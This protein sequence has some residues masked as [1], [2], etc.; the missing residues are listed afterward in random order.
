[1]KKTEILSLN[2]FFYVVSIFVLLFA[3][4][5]VFDI[6]SSED[7]SSIAASGNWSSYTDTS[8]LGS[9]T[10]EDPFLITSA[11]DLAGLAY[12]VNISG[13]KYSGKYFE[14]TCNISL[15]AHYWIPIGGGQYGMDKW[16]AGNYN[17]CG[18]NISGLYIS[19]SS[20]VCVG[21]FGIVKGG[22]IK[23]VN[24][25]SGTINGDGDTAAIVG[26]TEG[27]AT[28][29]EYCSNAASV[30]GTWR[31]GGIVGGYQNKWNAG[32][33]IYNCYNKGYVRGNVMVGGILGGQNNNG[34]YGIIMYCY[35]TGTI[36]GDGAGNDNKSL[37]G[38]IVGR[39]AGA[40]GKSSQSG[41]AMN[42]WSTSPVSK[43]TYVGGIA[44][45]FYYCNTDIL[46]NGKNYFNNISDRWGDG[47]NP[48]KNW[49]TYLSNLST[50]AK[51][52]NWYK[53]ASNWWGA[54]DMTSVWQIVGN[55]YPTFRTKTLTLN[56]NGGS[57][58]ADYFNGSGS[59][60]TRY[61]TY[62][63]YYGKLPTPTRTGYTFAGWYTAA[64]GGS[65][66][67]STNVY[68]SGN[69]T[70]FAHWT[71]NTYTV[72]Y[73]LG[74]GTQG[75]YLPTSWTYDVAQQISNPTRTGY[76]FDGWTASG[77][78]T[79]TAV[80]GTS[81]NPTTKWSSASTK[82]KASS[83]TGA[84]YFKNLR[85]TSGTITLT[86]NWTINQYDLNF[87]ANG[88][89]VS[90]QERP[91]NY[92]D[93]YGTLPTPTRT[94]YTFNGWFTAASGGNQVSATTTMGAS[95]TTIYAHWTANTYTVKFNDQSGTTNFADMVLIDSTYNTNGTYTFTRNGVTVTYDVSDSA[96]TLNGTPTNDIN[97]FINLGLSF[98]QNDVYRVSY[99]QISGSMTGSSTGAF[100]LEVCDSTWALLETRNR[101]DFQMNNSS[102]SANLTISS[103]G[104]TQG[105]GLK[106][107]FWCNENAT[108]SRVFNNFKVK[109][110]IEKSGT[111][112]VQKQTR[113]TYGSALEAVAPPTRVG[114][115]FQ[116]YYTQTGGRGTRYFDSSGHPVVSTMNIAN[117]TTTLHA[118]W[119]VKTNCVLTFN[120]NG[121]SVS[122]TSRDQTFNAALGTLPVP[123]RT[124]YIFTGWYT[125]ASGGDEVTSSTIME[126]ES[127]TIYA[128][129]AE[130][131]A[132]SHYSSALTQDSDGY[133]MISSSA[134]LARVLYLLNY[135]TRTDVLTMRFKLTDH[136][137]MSAYYWV[138]AG[139]ESRPFQGEFNG[140]GYTIK[141]LKTVSQSERKDSGG[142]NG[143]LF[144]VTS[145]GAIIKN[146]YLEDIDIHGLDRVGA[147]VGHVKG[148]TTITAVAVEGTVT[149]SGSNYG[150]IV[151]YAD[152][153]GLTN[154]SDC[155]VHLTNYISIRRGNVS[156]TTSI[157]YYSDTQYYYTGSNP[158]TNPSA[159]PNWIQN[160]TGM[161]YT[162][163]PKG[164]AWLAETIGIE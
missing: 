46:Q 20:H 121:G 59:T 105:S 109:F 19:Q 79:S 107:W 95:D 61:R 100:V 18:Y 8:W 49:T 78:S 77:L 135:T 13:N 136:I 138:Q 10:I 85:T 127:M 130:T 141:G 158:V 157:N 89:S 24:V 125:S 37:V 142:Y 144:G 82:V 76:T 7:N 70:L 50:K 40:D 69:T 67:T 9:G 122:P 29:I 152:Q 116:G 65:K 120:A 63:S 131:W 62:A 27:V 103:S 28:T 148:V 68:G 64:S 99:E 113:F 32:L 38:G 66:I 162:M 48:D 119:T 156:A 4:T 145:T 124:G 15:S 155:L 132:A 14:Q 153:S 128:H 42:T 58:S 96:L 86:A 34:Q 21:L 31:V 88:G 39:L 26:Y 44:G 57:V 41:Y 150:A 110:K 112:N 74:G 71:P 118:Y 33:M 73:S 134:D 154:I 140:Q 90:V 108:P 92:G 72:S 97:L 5:M 60:V 147:V 94:G 54:W 36:Y 35:S 98:T 2:K 12:L 111:Q 80:Y 30:Y 137:D 133:W 1:M 123:T 161:K 101:V 45:E 6:N 129:W 126:S 106:L 3:L 83:A 17:G 87:D 56:A 81:S 93:Q 43:N 16:F 149:A 25:T 55:N 22:T 51:D 159:W 84:L 160:L 163:L 23:G 164:L 52:I 139:T 146:V 91:L 114:Y 151:G 47:H 53:T 115:N 11:E 75:T 143:G 104:A 117:N 102:G